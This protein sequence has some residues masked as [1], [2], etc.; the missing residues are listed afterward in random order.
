MFTVS[1]GQVGVEVGVG[2]GG[3]ERVVT[4]Y[5]EKALDTKVSNV[6]ASTTPLW[7]ASVDVQFI[8][9]TG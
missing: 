9:Y 6:A 2:G 8:A 7:N 3:G 5:R 1:S 4:V